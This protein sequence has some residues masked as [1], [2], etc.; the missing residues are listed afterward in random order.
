LLRW[1]LAFPAIALP[2]LV[3][4]V[5]PWFWGG[6]AGLFFMAAPFFLLRQ[7]LKGKPDRK[8]F[9]LVAFFLLY[10]F[11]QSVPLPLSWLEILSPERWAWIEEARSLAGVQAS[12]APLSYVPLETFFGGIWWAFLAFYGLVLRHFIQDRENLGWLVQVLFLWTV[13][14]AAYGLLQVLVPGL[15]VL[16]HDPVG[17]QG[18]DFARGTFIYHNHF[19]AYLNLMWPPMLASV[20]ALSGPG[21]SPSRAPLSPSELEKKRQATHKR[22]FKGFLLMLTLLA[23]VFS[24]SRAG[25]AVS[26][27]VLTLFILLEGV[28]QRGLLAFAGVCWLGAVAYGILI[29]FH[30]LFLRFTQLAESAPGRLR[31][32]QDTLGIVKDHWAF[33]VGLDGYAPAIKIY[34]THL[35]DTLRLVHAHND[36]LELAAELGAPMALGLV[37][38]AWGYWIKWVLR[39]ARVRGKLPRERRL[40]AAGTL[41]ALA[42]FYLH[43]LVEFNWALPANQLAFVVVWTTAVTVLERPKV[44]V[45]RRKQAPS[46]APPFPDEPLAKDARWAGRPAS[47][48]RLGKTASRSP[49]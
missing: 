41:S 18:Q 25:I 33:G 17:F 35:P 16:W 10:P 23:L 8:T 4:G 2:L 31:I 20:L 15:G 30:K 29:G 5:Y 47:P 3:G 7:Q 19:A 49:R 1:V 12:A 26:L 46:S 27:V 28:R 6:V 39:F 32:W 37:A 11:F 40:M 9:F 45:R 42:G 34:Q 48:S 13:V 14:E 24:M 22:I 36:Y 44:R 38:C 43:G 21:A